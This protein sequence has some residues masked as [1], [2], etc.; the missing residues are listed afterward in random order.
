MVGLIETNSSLD[1]RKFNLK[2]P[3]KLLPMIEGKLFKLQ[4]EYNILLKNYY[5]R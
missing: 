1:M 5:Y 3:Q 2:Y 4:K